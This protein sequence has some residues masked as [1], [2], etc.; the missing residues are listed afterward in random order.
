MLR[1]TASALA[2]IALAGTA[3]ACARSA[4]DPATAAES[5]GPI[6]IWLSNN[7]QE[8]Q[9]GQNMVAD[10]NRQHPDQRVRAQ[11][12]PAGKT[13]EEAISASIIAG[14]SACLVFNTSPAS[15]PQFQKQ[16][17]LVPL[18]DFPDGKKYIES[19]SGSLAGQ[20]RSEDGKYYQLPWKSNPVMILYNKKIFAKA[21]LDPEH[22]RLAT[23]DQ[24]LATSRKLVKS[25]ATDA[26]IWPAPSSEFFQSW[27]D[28]YPAF[29][30]ESG[31]TSLVVDGKPQFDSPAGL[32]VADFWRSLYQ[33]K[34]APQE[35]YPG[36]ALADG[37]AAMATVGPWAIAAYKDKIDWGVVPVP[38]SDGRPASQIHTF[39][40]QKSIG[41]FSSCKNRATAWDVMKFATSEQEDGKFLSTTGQMP[42]REDLAHEYAGFFAKN[43]AYKPFADQ[44]KREVEV[45]NVAGSIDVWQTF[46]DAWTS[47]VVFGR[48]SPSSALRDAAAKTATIL[49]EY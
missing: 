14:T 5:R 12:I 37:K 44:A 7:A 22:P 49:G 4:P 28:F 33:E 3:A 46:R 30:A 24:F 35:L 23:Y 8:V 26:A 29:A 21:G 47:S 42:V 43:P 15:V 31:G 48:Q 16:A 18:N 10:W 38:T 39:S 13:S 2:V 32:K 6:T 36:D 41:M 25:G 34:L 40:D 45:P 19:R 1:R 9:W 17:G 27:F 20:Y 11:N